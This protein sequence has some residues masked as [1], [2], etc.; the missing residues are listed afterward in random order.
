LFFNERNFVKLEICLARGKK[1]HDK[2][3]TI[4]AKDEK[5]TMERVK[6]AFNR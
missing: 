2:R 5:K 3:E 4:K 1:V 6:K